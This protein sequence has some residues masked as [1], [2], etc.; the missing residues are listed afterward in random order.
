MWAN[1]RR[2]T[3]E[4]LQKIDFTKLDLSEITEDVMKNFKPQIDPKKHFAKGD[5]LKKHSMSGIRENMKHMMGGMSSGGK[6]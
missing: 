4:E 6:K 2:F 1:C 3:A 5:E